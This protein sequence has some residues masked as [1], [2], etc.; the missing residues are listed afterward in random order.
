MDNFSF[1]PS[2][3]NLVPSELREESDCFIADL[4][5]ANPTAP[6]DAVSSQLDQVIAE[7]VSHKR[8][9]LLAFFDKQA[10]ITQNGGSPKIRI[11]NKRQFKE[12][13]G[14]ILDFV[15][16]KVPG[17]QTDELSQIIVKQIMKEVC[18]V[19]CLSIQADTFS[20][21]TV[22]LCNRVKTHTTE[23]SSLARDVQEH[24]TK[25]ASFVQNSKQLL[26][27]SDVHD[28]L[29]IC[30]KI[31]S[32]EKSLASRLEASQA[33]IDQQDLKVELRSL[34]E[35]IKGEPVRQTEPSRISRLI[36]TAVKN[37]ASQAV[38]WLMNPA[39]SPIEQSAKDWKFMQAF[40][41]RIHEKC[42]QIKLLTDNNQIL[43]PELNTFIGELSHYEKIISYLED[44]FSA[45]EAQDL[46]LMSLND[47]IFAIK[48]GRQDFSSSPY[49][50][51]IKHACIFNAIATQHREYTNMQQ[52]A[53]QEAHAVSQLEELGMELFP[54]METELKE[55]NASWRQNFQM[56]KSTGFPDAS[57]NRLK[58]E[59]LHL[60]HTA[61]ASTQ[62][63]AD[64]RS[65]YLDKAIPETLR[66]QVK[67]D[68]RVAKGINQGFKSALNRFKIDAKSIPGFK[69]TGKVSNADLADFEH[70][71]MQEPALTRA[72]RVRQWEA[73]QFAKIDEEPSET[74]KLLY[75]AFFFYLQAISPSVIANFGTPVGKMDYDYYVRMM[76]QASNTANS[77][78]ESYD[79]Y[80]S[81][82][83]SFVGVD[84]DFLNNYDQFLRRQVQ[85]EYGPQPAATSQPSGLLSN[86]GA[87][88][89]EA[90][91][92][93]IQQHAPPSVTQWTAQFLGLTSE[94]K[95]AP[96][97]NAWESWVQ[98]SVMP[99]VRNH[100]FEGLT[101][102]FEKLGD[103]TPPEGN[104]PST[105]F[106][107]DCYKM[108]MGAQA[109]ENL[110]QKYP[111]QKTFL[112][113]YQAYLK[114][115]PP[116]IQT[117]ESVLS[118][119]SQAIELMHATGN[120]RLQ[121]QVESEGIGAIA[122][123]THV[124]T[125]RC[126]DNG[127]MQLQAPFLTAQVGEIRS[128]EQTAITTANRIHTAIANEMPV[129]QQNLARL[130]AIH[131]QLN[132]AKELLPTLFTEH[133][134]L[135]G[136]V[137]SVKQLRGRYNALQA[138]ADS[139]ST[140]T[141]T[142]DWL[143]E[144]QSVG[145]ELEGAV[146]AYD[147]L[148]LE[149]QQQALDILKQT[150]EGPSI[151]INDG[152]LLHVIGDPFGT[153]TALEGG[154][155]HHTGR[156]LQ[157]MVTNKLQ[158]LQGA[159]NAQAIMNWMGVDNEPGTPLPNE[160]QLLRMFDQG[161]SLLETLENLPLSKFQ[162]KLKDE[163]EKASIG[164]PVFIPGGWIGSP[165]GH[166]MGYE[167]I[168]QENGLYT[169]RIYNTGEGLKYHPTAIIEF[170][171]Q[172]IT[173]IE[174]ND[175][176]LENILR[177][178]TLRSLEELN[179]RMPAGTKN[180]PAY[181]AESIYLNLRTLLGGTAASHQHG[182]D[183]LRT[184]QM[185]GTCA[186]MSIFTAMSHRLSNN[187]MTKAQFELGLKALVE[188][189]QL[190]HSTIISAKEE[191]TIRLL[192]KSVEEFSR[193]LL[194][195]RETGVI[196][197]LEFIYASEKVQDIQKTITI[198]KSAL[199]S[200]PTLPL[201]L[202]KPLEP[203]KPI[204]MWLQ[205][206]ETPSVELPKYDAPADST[207]SISI[208]N[209][210]PSTSTLAADL[211][212]FEGEMARAFAAGND[213]V[214]LSSALE[215]MKKLP[216]N[217]SLEEM[218]ALSNEDAITV[219]HA[220]ASISKQS[221]NSRLRLVQEDAFLR[222]NKLPPSQLL[223][224]V[225]I[226]SIGHALSMQVLGAPPS[227]FLFDNYLFKYFMENPSLGVRF[228]D[229]SL[230]KEYNAITSHWS[231]I[232]SNA[233]ISFQD[234]AKPSTKVYWFDRM[235]NFKAPDPEIRA[236]ELSPS[237]LKILTDVLNTV[238]DYGKI[239]QQ[240][241]DN[242]PIGH[243]LLNYPGVREKIANQY[244][245]IDMMPDWVKFSFAMSDKF[246]LN[247]QDILE[248]NREVL[249]SFIYEL[250]DMTLVN[251]WLLE[252][253]IDKIP[254][255]EPDDATT[256]LPTTVEFETTTSCNNDHVCTWVPGVNVDWTGE[257]TSAAR[258]L[259]HGATM[260]SAS[261]ITKD[262]KLASIM[263]KNEEIVIGRGYV[264]HEV[265][266][267]FDPDEILVAS[268]SKEKFDG[269]SFQ[270]SREL[271]NLFSKDKLQTVSVVGYL[272]S[273]PELIQKPEIRL[274]LKN[275]LFDP[276]T[277]IP[278][279]A[280]S[281]GDAKLLFEKLGS[282]LQENHETYQKIGDWKTVHYIASLNSL[283]ES[284]AALAVTDY[285]VSD[286]IKSSFFDTR[287]EIRQI[288]STQNL[289][290]KIKPLFQ[291]EL[292]LTYEQN[293]GN[294]DKDQLTALLPLLFDAELH[295]H[296]L[297]I[298]MSLRMEAL[299]A[300]LQPDIEALATGPH[301]DTVL[302]AIASAIDGKSIRSQWSAHNAY[303]MFR[304]AESTTVV[305]LSRGKMYRSTGMEVGLN[306][307][308]LADSRLK[309]VL[310]D[311]VP[312]N[313]QQ[314][315]VLSYS[316]IGPNEELYR[317]RKE[318]EGDITIQKSLGGHW[319]QL[320]QPR[321]KS[322]LLLGNNFWLCSETTPPQMLIESPKGKLLYTAELSDD[323]Q[324]ITTIRKTGAEGPLTLAENV[325]EFLTVFDDST[326]TLAWVD[327]HNQLKELSFP[328]FELEFDIKDNKAFSR[329]HKGFYISPKQNLPTLQP[330]ENYL[331]LENTKGDKLVLL[332]DQQFQKAGKNSS[333]STKEKASLDRRTIM[334][335]DGAAQSYFAYP[336]DPLT[337]R[338][339]PPS[340]AARFHL[341]MINLWNMDYT[342]AHKLLRG[343]GESLEP[344]TS[345][346]VKHLTHIFDLKEASNDNDPR[347]IALNTYASYLLQK[348]AQDF[349]ESPANEFNPSSEGLSPYLEVIDKVGNIR[350]T[351][352]EEIFLLSKRD[353]LDLK[354]KH[355]L[356]YL[357]TEVGGEQSNLFVEIPQFAPRA[358]TT[359]FQEM[360]ASKVFSE[361][362]RTDFNDVKPTVMNFSPQ[363][364]F[365]RLYKL[366][367]GDVT[368]SEADKMY[369]DITGIPVFP[370]D[371]I[372]QKKELNSI[373]QITQNSPYL[374]IIRAL[375]INP[376]RFPNYDKIDELLNQIRFRRKNPTNELDT[377]L[378]K[379]TKEILS[380][381]EAQKSPD[382][383]PSSTIQKAPS[384]TIWPVA[385]AIETPFQMCV[386]PYQ[387]SDLSVAALPNLSTVINQVPMAVDASKNVNE[388]LVALFDRPAANRVVEGE[389][390][391]TKEQLKGYQEDKIADAEQ[392]GVKL[393]TIYQV[394]DAREFASLRG[395]IEMQ[396]TS[397]S[398]ELNGL[399]IELLA[400]ANKQ[401]ENDVQHASK[402]LG[403]IANGRAPISIDDLLNLFL[404]RDMAGFHEA[405]P[406]LTEDDIFQ[407]N[408][409][410]SDYLIRSTHLQH[411]H[412][413][414]SRMND[415]Q[416]ATK[417]N[418]PVA[419]LSEM[420]EELV[421]HASAKR[422]YNVQDNPEYLVFEHYANILLRPS[423][424]GNLDLLRIKDGKIRSPDQLG[425]VLESIMGSGKTEVLLPLLGQLCLSGD[426]LCFAIIPEPL[427]AD[428]SKRLS[429]IL[430]GA[431]A[432]SVE[433]VSFRRDESPNLKDLKMLQLR[434]EQ[435]VTSKRVL[436]MS[437]SSIQGIYLKF[438][439]TWQQASSSEGHADT[440]EQFKIMR[441]IMRIM[442]KGVAMIDEADLILNARKEYQF[443]L[444]ASQ[445]L[446]AE[447]GHV[448]TFLYKQL[449]D[450]KV[451]GDMRFDFGSANP[452]A[453]IFNPST[454][455]KDVAPRL[456]EQM[457]N[458]HL[459]ANNAVVSDFFNKLTA[460]ESA[461]VKDYLSGSASEEALHFYD[462]I[463]SEMVQDL[464]ALTKQNIHHLIPLTANKLADEYYGPSPDP[465]LY[466]AIP[467]HGS[468]NPAAKSRY[469]V[470]ET[471][472]YTVQLGILKPINQNII[473]AE[474]EGLQQEAVKLLNRGMP[475]AGSAIEK[476]FLQLTGGDNTIQLFGS[477]DTIDKISSYVNSKTELKLELI[478]RYAI[479]QITNHAS[480]LSANAQV[481]NFLFD[482][483]AGFTGT[484]W[485]ADTFPEKLDVIP[486]NVPVGSTFETLWKKSQGKVYGFSVADRG[487]IIH[488]IFTEQPHLKDM[489]SFIDTAGLARGVANE[490]IAKQ[491]LALLPESMKGVVY[492]DSS[493]NLKV[494]ERGA[495]K[496]TSLSQSK[497]KPEERVTFY[498][499]KHTTGTN[500]KQEYSA[501]GLVTI[502]KSTIERDVLQS[503][504]RLRGLT[505]GQRVEFLIE[506]E[507]EEIIKGVLQEALGEKPP[508]QLELQHLLLYLS[509]SQAMVKG[510][511]N[512]R[513]LKQKL[514][515]V[516]Q[517]SVM[518][519]A[520][521]E[522]VS[523]DHLLKIFP[524]VSDLCLTK[525]EMSPRHL[526]GRPNVE[527]KSD[528]V[529]DRLVDK[530]LASRPYKLF[531]SDAIVGSKVNLEKIK[532]Q[533]INMA[534]KSRP[535]VH[536]TILT[537]SSPYQSEQ[538]LEVENEQ[539]QENQLE[540]E[541][542]LEME[543][544]TR[545][546]GRK[547]TVNT[548]EKPTIEDLTN[549][550][551]YEEKP[552]EAPT[553][554]FIG[555]NTALGNDPALEEFKGVFDSN[556]VA[557][558]QLIRQGEG[559]NKNE[560]QDGI[561]KLF[562]FYQKPASDILIVEDSKTNTLRFVLGDPNDGSDWKEVLESERTSQNGDTK[563]LI[564]RPGY[565]PYRNHGVDIDRLEQKTQYH[566]VLAQ[567]KFLN[568]E[569]NYSKE[570][571]IYLKEWVSTN[572][573]EKMK[574]LF[575]H[576]IEYKDLSRQKYP[577]SPLAT[578]LE[579]L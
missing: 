363:Y 324:T 331:I 304:N 182:T 251:R 93:A 540:L 45:S 143:S 409:R 515:G 234:L 18:P 89:S 110:V 410:V 113:D 535:L 463:A 459:G 507:A 68:L 127:A 325:P 366:L 149:K 98:Q 259:Q 140:I 455:R 267:R 64:L 494:L 471:L 33:K 534:D 155:T 443:T 354:E 126:F 361:L 243:S 436:F 309:K 75:N 431:F 546:H 244:P 473:K 565:G 162:D 364:A 253:P 500:I 248:T 425:T 505:R 378:L 510:D 381:I 511:N 512:F 450:P 270:Q 358:K 467:Y 305:D 296:D 201:S 142:L 338:L 205:A 519:V 8:L 20:A 483:V 95:S 412:R 297:P 401:S 327:D 207:Y 9:D 7:V 517:E 1:R 573:A 219:I 206:V 481:F 319:H 246:A 488:Q 396:I 563:V 236:E 489:K 491:W 389:F 100:Y 159:G 40:G 339:T 429:Q 428:M 176:P 527:E 340:G 249:P 448:V 571:M 59:Y 19:L 468:M 84:Q 308:I 513:S 553:A 88:T 136:I 199:A 102:Y 300:K 130:E 417:N 83:R 369:H 216:F 186:M 121:Q 284:Y 392:R 485:N 533:V 30:K 211:T 61:R 528:L 350:L 187:V 281:P 544:D 239:S 298:D 452:D 42:D 569:I 29:W 85:Y 80:L 348:N 329:K 557:S 53:Y 21:N 79:H 194:T 144:L 406:H 288:L 269:F 403:D 466:I 118:V 289:S 178:S 277:F 349:S 116:Q 503:V 564:Y 362:A 43:D 135:K 28:S 574:K 174:D 262:F 502:G 556:L 115:N 223:N 345:D 484:Q 312:T 536:D 210:T 38:N 226:W 384:A 487:K 168:K 391:R 472:N 57:M 525:T 388:Q 377:L 419:Q 439:E 506:K 290:A 120:L 133:S 521:A 81:K 69:G 242:S 385:Q 235:E 420:T 413:L 25:V 13:V 231:S 166:R 123:K 518:G 62:L 260:D 278:E 193:H 561:Y 334:Q 335:R 119:D 141:L 273:H 523:T 58:Q 146:E 6:P 387:T 107:Y 111:E 451:C 150:I 252:Y 32:N 204:D 509:Y 437:P 414:S 27:A 220:L 568:G 230:D 196:N 555:L 446:P 579:A 285:G 394:K 567:A 551:F 399:E 200:V 456:I 541:L 60:K 397:G 71:R 328:R 256:P 105:N 462:H 393:N 129:V 37:L 26:S 371:P 342:E 179:G 172:A 257:V 424:V 302:N 347:A 213:R 479:P 24:A 423:Q 63:V 3:Y 566:Q 65:L 106:G 180:D 254:L 299:L 474:V 562:N 316:F 73:R 112:S 185:A 14:E 490:D 263:T 353:S 265:T 229:P 264:P 418:T 261:G 379:P 164:Q 422:A 558:L 52:V 449:L 34:L 430:G 36:P 233:S 117:I 547:Y 545:G 465:F 575:N 390:A 274:L 376:D 460:D 279:I 46:A 572:G 198:G 175:I 189:E 241:W 438:W 433:V 104:D 221:F 170:K 411:L 476:R 415:I 190:N 275:F 70:A 307:S 4:S 188:Y 382:L 268:A 237:Q 501:V 215:I 526:F 184:P 554:R 346:E 344:F 480:K 352:D 395:S 421:E 367:K 508:E 94:G 360:H 530:T 208:G 114:A 67:S 77:T 139:R 498:D 202:D 470:Y 247:H 151:G 368:G 314:I 240:K 138:L 341:A 44:Y 128:R 156:L 157:K 552:L 351:R 357:T 310:G 183:Q 197:D 276:K 109:G 332:P 124:A 539:E 404:T 398:Y 266:K 148:H 56:G 427:L 486:S 97:T 407:L 532:Q 86:S 383:S 222:S 49:L 217:E 537:S 435:A 400:Q 154:I 66:A 330:Y 173:F 101:N 323:L 165:G 482:T 306:L 131:T 497:L 39:L 578:V 469:E 445:S 291:A 373:F 326:S 359:T 153:G 380:N 282:F 181:E 461:L 442:K 294:L 99:Q 549:L 559:S 82:A 320:E 524:D 283:C 54:A 48:E 538:E 163:L 132:I 426:N 192:S 303:P 499:Q 444:G 11:T 402:V 343:F 386:S 258:K 542:E 493:D 160:I 576:I 313:M 457:M 214:V 453:P 374:Q 2:S 90:V 441:S 122:L 31:Q 311:F 125:E 137:E 514:G 322:G 103:V 286:T 152:L 492:Y 228:S 147:K 218:K 10:T 92:K 416:V 432:K 315:G 301:K 292:A 74:R 41:E 516:L 245:Q 333:L 5:P 454:Y 355:R 191:H 271:M 225:K 167:F 177:L 477:S 17:S 440:V 365:D 548:F 12:K 47:Q 15:A 447:Q 317:I 543:V 134:E 577:D 495:T 458:H 108:Y 78:E 570:E 238:T 22:A 475:F 76:A 529:I 522:D 531:G 280:S 195:A 321:L 464:L 72:Q 272:T 96:Q 16:K 550:E 224:H 356:R 35:E 203:L 293:H 51:V 520:M 50:N 209:W 336:I 212:H 434:M 169:F 232:S 560:W 295:V 171:R 408:G 250:A 318:V 158:A 337:N 87:T 55:A 91:F 227:A 478:E 145:K 496:P 370:K 161:L 375:M 255:I 287:A 405:N 372:E 504:W 23:D